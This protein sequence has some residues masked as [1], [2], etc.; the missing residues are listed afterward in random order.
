MLQVVKPGGYIV[1]NLRATDTENDYMVRFKEV[2]KKLEDDGKVKHLVTE[3]V[4]HFKTETITDMFSNLF[5][6][7]KL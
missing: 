3:K 7:R 5:V 1:F 6:F 4:A 2:L